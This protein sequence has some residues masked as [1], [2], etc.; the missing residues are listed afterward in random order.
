MTTTSYPGVERRRQTDRMI[1]ELLTE[2]KEMWSAYWEVAKLK[3]FDQHQEALT[4]TLA[5]FCQIMID[6]ISLGHFGIYHRII[7][8]TERRQRA[9]QAAQT[10]YPEIAEA[11]EVAIKFNELYEGGK[12]SDPVVLAR[13]L[14]RLGEAL[15]KRIEL[16]DRLIDSLSK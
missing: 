13:E 7:N 3:P 11:T 12:L 2:R 1:Y 6:Y 15:A 16:E 9:I 8:G 10:L 4:Q 5:R 14:S